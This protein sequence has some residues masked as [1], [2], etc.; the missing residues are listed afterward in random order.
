MR[1]KLLSFL[2]IILFISS[3]SSFG[4][5][6]DVSGRV[7]LFTSSFVS[8]NGNGKYFSHKSGDFALKR[9]ETRVK[10]S[11]SLND[12]ISYNLRF[13]AFSNAGTLLSG[14]NFP[15]SGI[16][17]TPYPTEYFE[18]NLYEANII[19]SDFLIKNLDLTIGKQRISWGTADKIGV[20]DNLNPLDFA[21]FFTF[22]PDYSFE[23]RPQTALNFEYYIGDASKMQFVLLLQHQIAPL[24][25]G[26]SLLTRR[27]MQVENISIEK[28]WENRVKDMNFGIRF[29]TNLFNTDFGISFYKGNIS[30]PFLEAYKI[31]PAKE[32][33]FFYGKE[34]IIGFDFSTVISGA[35]I[36]GEIAYHIPEDTKA[37]MQVP[38]IVNNIPVGIA[39]M[40][41][42]LFEKGFFKYV[43][44]GDYTFS[45]GFYVNLQYLHGFFDEYDFTAEA[46]KYFLKRKG[47]FF[48]E[49]SDY[50]IPNIEYKFH[51]DEIKIIFSGI[52]EFSEENSFVL[53]PMIEFR[54]A[55]GL[56]LSAGGFF[57]LLG[58]EEKTKF[59]EFKKDRIVFVS[60]KI[61]F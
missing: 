27:A 26:Y 19:L 28:D 46:E 22:D 3:L 21:N 5:D 35:T 59:G 51:N 20:V 11:G 56:K 14:V 32:G 29:T 48:G 43:V 49:I 47:D 55:D 33:D 16:L 53:S 30:L 4:K 13:D 50:F 31:Y 44:G 60:M 34:N 17:S 1:K 15:E 9:V 41:F 61:D 23:K 39:N 57:V 36:W 42:P 37:F 52:A 8:E 12:R 10:F 25:Y 45:G 18:L 58:D 40:D 6:I 38:V 24:P 7:K 2:V 54:V